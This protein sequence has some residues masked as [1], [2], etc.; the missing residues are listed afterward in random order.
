MNPPP[1]L[2][3]VVFCVEPDNQDAAADVWRTLGLEFV[4]ILLADVSLRVL[5]DWTRG[6][7]IISPTTSDAT[8]CAARA[9]L[10]EHREGIYSVV[11]RTDAISA[12][13]ESMRS[14]GAELTY[15]QSRS[16]DGYTLEEAQF[17]PVFGMPITLLETDH[18]EA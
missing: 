17:A 1:S 7:E 10:N 5:L 13:T 14:R 11:V 18:A 15:R 4:E 8:V 6:V 16:G 3:H 2:H 12:A 9:F